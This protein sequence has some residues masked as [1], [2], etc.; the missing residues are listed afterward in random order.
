MKEGKEMKV[1]GNEELFIRRYISETFVMAC[2]ERNIRVKTVCKNGRVEVVNRCLKNIYVLFKIG[3]GG[4]GYTR[5]RIERIKLEWE[6]VDH[7]LQYTPQINS[8]R[9]H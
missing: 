5:K 9:N 4:R 6:N 7:W 3:K 2:K 1:K 8:S